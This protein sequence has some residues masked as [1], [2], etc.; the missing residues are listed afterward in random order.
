MHRLYGDGEASS[1]APNLY[2]LVKR[3]D[4]DE[5]RLGNYEDTPMY[6]RRLAGPGLPAFNR[7]LFDYQVGAAAPP[8][9]RLD[10]VGG[11]N[12]C[13]EYQQR[14]LAAVAGSDYVVTV[15][16]RPEGLR[17]ARAFMAAFFVDR[18]DDEIPGSRRVSDLVSAT[19]RS[20][21]PW[22][23]VRVDLPGDHPDAYA[24]RVQLWVLQAYSWRGV[25]RDDPDPLIVQDV[26]A[27]AWF[28]DLSVLRLP[29]TRLRLSNAGG[30]VADSPES[31]VIEVHNATPAA[32]S[33]EL[34]LTD[35]AGRLLHERRLELPSQV[36]GAET[37]ADGAPGLALGEFQTARDSP[38]SEVHYPVPP[39]P[40]GVYRAGFRLVAAGERLL[41]REL[42]FAVLA[43]LPPPRGVFADLGVYLG[44]FAGGD[45]VAL[46]R[47]LA[48][49]ACGAAK[50]GVPLLDE[51]AAHRRQDDLI[52]L[53]EL[54]RD[55]NEHRIETT[56]VLLPLAAADDGNVALSTR[57]MLNSDPQWMRALRPV[58]TRFGGL[59]GDWQV[60]DE[61][62]EL[63]AGGWSPAAL[64]EL[65]TFVTRFVTLPRLIRPHAVTRPLS[66]GSDPF[67]LL[68]PA[69]LPPHAW[70]Q[71]LSAVA[72]HSSAC[73][74]QL[75]FETS[76]RLGRDERL[77]D[78]AQ[79]VILAK[80]SGAQRTYVPAPFELV[81]E[82]D[83]RRWQPG[84]EF[85]VLRTLF[86]VL[87]GARL[88]ARFRPAPDQEALL[89]TVP[90]GAGPQHGQDGVLA[91]WTW[92]A[93]A[94]G[95]PVGLHLGSAAQAIDLWGRPA[96]IE[97]DGDRVRLR[98]SPL[99]T[100]ILNVDVGL[101]QLAASIELDPRH[102]QT[103][104]DEPPPVLRLTNPY[105][106]RLVGEVLLD[107]PDEWSV[108]PERLPLA[109]EPGQTFE[110]SLAFTLPPRQWAADH[111]L[112]VHLRISS[113][114]PAMLSLT[115]PLRVGLTDVEVDAR[116]YWELP[117]APPRSAGQARPG[118]P[119][120]G[121]LAEDAVLVVEQTVVNRSRRRVSFSGF[122][123]A[124]G[125]AQ[126]LAAHL[127]LA[128]GDRSVQRYVFHNAG[129]LRGRTLMLGVREI[130]G[131][132]RVDQLVQVPE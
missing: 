42:R 26:Q 54:L 127:G 43:P 73:W 99:P 79:R 16:I 23:P 113:P 39:L 85:L 51:E 86:H 111:D 10:I 19:G 41:D 130:D 11:G 112:G 31:F 115:L 61:R 106:Q 126:Q 24:V 18:F 117:G 77:A 44:P 40:P 17:A 28:D 13:Y 8:S 76:P 80:A 50:V 47:L 20:P 53:G 97:R 32:I 58:L 94:P 107:L 91:I 21:E 12:V 119:P 7:G 45:R 103:Y 2:R 69:R 90:P 14:D 118:A 55:L 56:A 36:A 105:A 37:A 122:A 6:W 25:D 67:S 120:P 62:C 110:Q 78:L 72:E 22:Q 89:F 48:A 92:C 131:P 4:F 29:R 129:G 124:P 87:S 125:R 30:F 98:P 109:V 71:Q 102:V 121:G 9:F 128:P 95:T 3:F 46:R 100:L 66:P 5:R 108:S 35:L 63:A 38:L 81:D 123:D 93:N 82:G 60:G 33:A 57:S 104:S 96:P 65:R 132:R 70:Q 1:A 75:E 15:S 27:S 74:L 84:E 64:A 88:A 114:R 68:V 116:V 52:Q 49:M 83:Q 34:Y 101:A 59:L